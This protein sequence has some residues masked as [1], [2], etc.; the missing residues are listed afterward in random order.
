MQLGVL[1]RTSVESITP[2]LFG[3]FPRILGR[4][5]FLSF[6]NVKFQINLKVF[7]SFA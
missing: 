6:G 4:C 3:D 5:D 1:G 2:G 7:A